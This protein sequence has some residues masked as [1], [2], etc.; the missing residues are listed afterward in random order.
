MG[1]FFLFALGVIVGCLIT[2]I[3]SRIKIVGS[4][5]GDAI[6]EDGLYLFLEL[7]EP[8]YKVLRK[9]YI[10]LKVNADEYLTH[11]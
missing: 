1:Y 8:V 5:R 10:T 6:D 4:L 11:K 3:R 2:V 9:K 7:C